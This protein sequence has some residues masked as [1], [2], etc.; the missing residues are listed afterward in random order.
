MQTLSY[1][2]T[3]SF[4]AALKAF[5][6]GLNVPI[7]YLADAPTDAKTV[8]GDTYKPDNKAHALMDEVYVLGVV[9]DAIFQGKRSLENLP[10]LQNIGKDYYG[11]LLLGIQ[12]RKQSNGLLPNRSQLAE[13]T[14]SFNQVFAYTPVS[15]V[16]QY[17][18]YISFANG[19]RSSYKQAWRDGEKVGKI[20]MLKEVNI[21]NPHA[22]HTRI[23]AELELKPDVHSFHALQQ[24]WSKVFTTQELNHQFFKKIANWYFWA[25]ANARFPYQYLQKEENYADY[26]PEALQEIANQK[27]LIRFITR[28]IFVWFLKEKK[29]IPE[30]FFDPAFLTKI[31]ID[32]DIDKG[33]NYYLAILQNLFFATLNRPVA[34]RAFAQDKGFLKNRAED[35]DINSLYR[36]ENLFQMPDTDTIM[37]YFAEIPFLNGGLFDS[38]D[39]KTENILIDGFSRNANMRASFPNFLLFGA[40]TYDFSPKLNDIYQ[41][42][43]A[44]YEVKGLFRIFEEYKFTLEENTPDEQDIALDPV[45]LGEIFE[46]LLAYYNPETATTARKGTGSFYTP[47]EIVNYMVEESIDAYLF[48]GDALLE[49]ASPSLP[50]E[51][52]VFRLSNIKMLDPAC[53]SGAFPM[54]VLHKIVQLLKKYDPNNVIWQKIQ[55]QKL[56]AALDHTYDIQDKAIRESEIQKLNDVFEKNLEDY[57]RK[58][59]II[60]NCIYGVDIQ[61][62]AIQIAKLRFFLSLVIDQRNENIQPLPNLETKFVVANTLI[63]V[64]LPF[65][66]LMAEYDETWQQEDPTAE[67]K[68]QLKKVRE[69]H[70]NATHRRQKQQLK[71]KD[72]ALRKELT[73]LI[74]TTL[75][76][77]REAKLAELYAFQAPLQQELE[78]A[79]RLPPEI[80]ETITEDMFGKKT[81]HKNDKTNTKIQQIESRLL[82]IDRKI[83]RLESHKLENRVIATAQNL[84]KWDIYDQ[85]AQATWF[86]SE[87]MFGLTEG[88]DVVIGNP[89]YIGIAKLKDKKVLEKQNFATFESTG[90]IYSLFY[91]KGIQLLKEKGALNYITSNKWMKAG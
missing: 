39:K 34:Q 68:A 73:Q 25:V 66:D 64:D 59:Y 30:K 74:Q 67:I 55:K 60:R 16:F 80:V 6:E 69:Q 23:L 36:Y 37:A 27:A 24:Q 18:S 86:D 85:N 19:E 33:E 28:I 76:E 29:L 54:G 72:E 89:P 50:P 78:A 5:F 81:V 26:K 11:L 42:K 62:V 83:L 17:E 9:D 84:A 48:E 87:W 61:D 21:L 40:E 88:F 13:I 14:R 15:I 56:L 12:L 71:H 7:N 31:L 63:G 75:I 3:H 51:E 20:T 45:L 44:K 4:L 2:H 57:G 49:S 8:L 38:L 58:L 47:Q 91:E 52:I 53:G 32:F 79:K 41:T 70:F 43:K 1:F 77:K 10:D 90:D 35:F 22:A 46:N 82:P 65:D